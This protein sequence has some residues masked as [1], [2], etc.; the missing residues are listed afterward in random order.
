MAAPCI[1]CRRNKTFERGAER[2]SDCAA[3][4]DA[5]ASRAEVAAPHGPDTAADA[6]SPGALLGIGLVGQL[7]GGLVMVANPEAAGNGGLLIGVLIASAGGLVAL[8][9]FGVRVSIQSAAPRESPRGSP[10]ALT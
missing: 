9:A 8:I 3:A 6:V 1:E 7:V 4:Y 5:T 2:C 10:G